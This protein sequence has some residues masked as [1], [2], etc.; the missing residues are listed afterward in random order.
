MP[1]GVPMS[2]EHKAKLAEGRARKKATKQ[3][4]NLTSKPKAK[5]PSRPRAV[6]AKCAECMGFSRVDKCTS[7]HCPLH[8]FNKFS[9]GE[10]S[11][12][13]TFP[14]ADWKYIAEMFQQKQGCSIED[15]VNAGLVESSNGAYRIPEGVKKELDR[16]M[17]G[18]AARETVSKPAQSKPAQTTSKPTKPAA[19]PIS[20]AKHI[21]P[22]WV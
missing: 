3:A 15:L 1:K 13:F 10:S 11:N 17:S 2:D 14:I 21:L 5:L 16:K 22:D 19:E 6:K 12:W 9:E 18:V 20:E 8:A 4:G 7:V